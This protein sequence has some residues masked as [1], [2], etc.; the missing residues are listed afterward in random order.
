MDFNVDSI[1]ENFGFRIKSV[2]V[3]DKIHV[4]KKK[5][6]TKKP[7]NENNESRKRRSV[8]YKEYPERVDRGAGSG[9]K[10][11][12][13]KGKRMYN[14]ILQQMKGLPEFSQCCATIAFIYHDMTPVL[15]VST[16]SK[17]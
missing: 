12:L 13:P 14:E 11:K 4:E 5:D 2:Y 7:E 9:K 3:S 10:K 8:N 6:T 15:S 17:F 1:A 16:L